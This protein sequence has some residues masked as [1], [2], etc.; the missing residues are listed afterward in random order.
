VYVIQIVGQEPPYTYF[1]WLAG[2]WCI[3]GLIIVLSQPQL[4]KRIGARLTVED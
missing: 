3:V 1:P 4:A 2:A